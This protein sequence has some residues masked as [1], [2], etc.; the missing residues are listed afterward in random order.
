MRFLRSTAPHSRRTTPFLS[1]LPPSSAACRPHPLPAALIRRPSPS[2]TA[3]RPLASTTPSPLPS[4]AAAA[5][6]A[7][8]AAVSL[9]RA[10][11]TRAHTVTLSHTASALLQASLH[12]AVP[13]L[14]VAPTRR[15][16]TPPRPQP[17]VSSTSAAVSTPLPRRL[18]APS[19]PLPPSCAPCPPVSSLAIASPLVFLPEAAEH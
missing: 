14:N 10:A 1:R 7:A 12:H 5:T 16:C 2:S 6:A 19:R 4:H 17:V 18:D 8:L 13:S 15:L 9:L 3:R 11:A